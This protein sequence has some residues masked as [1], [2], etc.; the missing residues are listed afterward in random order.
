[1]GDAMQDESSGRVLIADDDA[2]ARETLA[3]VLIAEGFA[4]RTVD[5]GS[6]ALDVARV[7]GF[8]VAFID[9]RMPGAE[10]LEVVQALRRSRACRR[11]FILTAY[12]EPGFTRRALAR[13]ADHV[14]VKPLDVPA[15]LE[16]LKADSAPSDRGWRVSD[17][18]EEYDTY[19]ADGL[20][21]RE[22]QVLALIAQGKHN[23]Q[24]AD[25]LTLSPRTVERHVGNILAQLGVTSRAAAAAIAIR[26]RLV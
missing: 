17:R 8:D 24:I 3:D 2:G 22:V 23:Q 19:R 13:G 10:G 7:E 15:V 26:D 25:E 11:I 12:A 18:R 4:V 9:Q 16:M 5:D 14:F 20:T 6:A 21:R 1:M